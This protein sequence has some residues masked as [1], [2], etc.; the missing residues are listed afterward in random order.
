MCPPSGLSGQGPMRSV[1]F[2]PV[3]SAQDNA[4][5]DTFSN[6]P[7]HRHANE[8]ASVLSIRLKDLLNKVHVDDQSYHGVK[9][10]SEL[11][12]NCVLPSRWAARPAGP[13]GEQTWRSRGNASGGVPKGS[14]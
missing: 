4:R 3:V 14:P 9:Q 10:V 7:A 11:A 12:G 13:S 1:T 5:T 6:A 2:G 8:P